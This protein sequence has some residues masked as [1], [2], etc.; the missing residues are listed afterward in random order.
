MGICKLM[1]FRRASSELNES[2]IMDREQNRVR[3]IIKNS[4]FISSDGLLDDMVHPNKDQYPHQR[5]VTVAMGE[6]SLCGSR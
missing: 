6:G 4:F 2:I 1:R 5:I 3:S